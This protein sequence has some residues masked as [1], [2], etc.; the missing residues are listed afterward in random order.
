MSSLCGHL[1]QTAPPGG[2]GGAAVTGVLSQHGGFLNFS[3]CSSFQGLGGGLH[4]KDGLLQRR[5]GAMDFHACSASAG[6]GL[7][8]LTNVEV[9][10]SLTFHGCEAIGEDSD[11]GGGGTRDPLRM[12]FVIQKQIKRLVAVP[13]NLQNLQ[14]A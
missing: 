11:D 9:N 6:G 3:E 5:A 10:G 1:F 2:G 14:S 4:V 12:H 13:S 7:Y 8:V